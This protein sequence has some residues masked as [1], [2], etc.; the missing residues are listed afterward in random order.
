MEEATRLSVDWLST[1]VPL[2]KK[3]IATTVW[4]LLVVMTEDLRERGKMG[5]DDALFCDT[6]AAMDV[7]SVQFMAERGFKRDGDHFGIRIDR[8]GRTDMEI[9]RD[10]QLDR[11]QEVKKKRKVGG[12]R[13][14]T[15]LAAMEMVSQRTSQSTVSS[16]DTALESQKQDELLSGL[17]SIPGNCPKCGVSVRNVRHHVRKNRC[18]NPDGYACETCGREFRD[19]TFLTVHSTKCCGCDGDHLC[20]LCGQGFPVRLVVN[21][22]KKLCK[23]RLGFSW[24]AD[25][26]DR[27]PH[28]LVIFW[29]REGRGPPG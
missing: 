13:E 7:W 15:R 12:G 23:G 20:P 1:A 4:K 9:L 17:R 16:Q 3:T 25:V 24:E 19:K 8:K 6:E 27:G 18:R 14:K 5:A 10:S 11:E 22:H 2:Q 26:I 29:H 28:R 21:R